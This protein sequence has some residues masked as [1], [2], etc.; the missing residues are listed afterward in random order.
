[1]GPVDYLV[2]EFP[3]NR[4]TGEGFPLLLDLVERNVIR[5]LDLLFVRKDEDG[6]VTALELQDLGDEVDLSVFAGASS[7]LLDQG[8]IDEAGAALE[9]NSSA[10][11]LVYEN[12]WAAPFARAMR[13]SGAQLVANGRIPVQALLA[14]LDA[15]EGT[16]PGGRAA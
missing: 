12:V 13:R 15:V 5:I 4:M 1:M 6:T 11:I 7:G 3:G 16:T 2:V 8:D 10:G 9:P 14:S